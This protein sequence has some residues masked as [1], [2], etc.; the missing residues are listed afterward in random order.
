MVII[1]GDQV[2]IGM[3]I[4]YSGIIAFFPL[5]RYVIGLKHW[6]DYSVIAL[7]L[8]LYLWVYSFY[9]W[10]I[11]LGLWIGVFGVVMLITSMVRKYLY[12]RN[13]HFF[14]KLALGSQASLIGYL[15]FLQVINLIFHVNL[16]HLWFIAVSGILLIAGTETLGY[17]QIKRGPVEG[18]RRGII[19]AI[20]ALLVGVVFRWRTLLVSLYHHQELLIIFMGITIIVSTWRH[21]N[22]SDWVRFSK[23]LNKKD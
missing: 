14:A 13:L 18:L 6:K 23:I 5:L 2:G 4:A 16:L 17:L 10:Y 22:I 9:H 20:S 7:G 21:L 3:L 19:T 12:G 1:Q 11:G 15:V 8:S